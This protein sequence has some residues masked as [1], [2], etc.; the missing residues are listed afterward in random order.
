M[1]ISNNNTG[2]MKAKPT[3][4]FVPVGLCLSVLLLWVGVVSI[5]FSNR[6]PQVELSTQGEFDLSKSGQFGDSFGFANSLFSCLGACLIVL[7]V[8]LQTAQLK[9][10]QGEIHDNWRELEEQRIALQTSAKI[11]AMS[12][13]VQAYA[14]IYA[15]DRD[16]ADSEYAKA[17]LKVAASGKGR[18]L[19]SAIQARDQTVRGQLDILIS[20][21]REIDARLIVE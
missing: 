18:E 11:Q 1:N 2:E 6:I 15:A 10:Q 3:R 14:A 5:T 20:S 12:G 7:T 19:E 13:M 9:L 8:Y 21:L 16:K 4:R 17:Q